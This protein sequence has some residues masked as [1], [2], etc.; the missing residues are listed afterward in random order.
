MLA[1]LAAA[2]RIMQVPGGWVHADVATELSGRLTTQLAAWH[3][4]HPDQPGATREELIPNCGLTP[5]EFAVALELLKAAGTIRAS[6]D[7]LALASHQPAGPSQADQLQ[8]RVEA[9][10]RERPFAPPEAE[11]LAATWK[12]E[13]FKVSAAVR[14]LLETKVLIRIAADVVLHREAIDKARAILVEEIRQAGRLESVRF[15]Y[16]LDTSRKYAIP[17]LDYFDRTGLTRRDNNTRYL[18]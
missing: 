16:L 17:L 13:P 12:T 8:T 1:E 2:G 3:A 10:Y 7:R 15:K 18:R 14:K 5:A 4:A 9:A 6:G 11:E